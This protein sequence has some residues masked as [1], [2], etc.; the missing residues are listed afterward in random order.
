M[1]DGNAASEKMI[2]RSCPWSWRKGGPAR[3]AVKDYPKGY[4][5]NIYAQS[6]EP[7]SCPLLTSQSPESCNFKKLRFS[8]ALRAPA[9]RG[10]AADHVAFVDQ[11]RCRS[12]VACTAH[13]RL[14]RARAAPSLLLP[15]RPAP[16]SRVG[17]ALPAPLLL[18]LAPR[19][20]LIPLSSCVGAALRAAALVIAPLNFSF[21]Q[22]CSWALGAEL[23]N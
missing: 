21:L 14:V 23:A 11:R 5:M 13:S 22:R 4:L 15:M 18:S 20:A 9:S 1:Y 2:G 16:S 8:G 12:F 10:P 19:A 3:R 7:P 17:A 6:A